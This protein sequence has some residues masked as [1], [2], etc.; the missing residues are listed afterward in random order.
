MWVKEILML[1]VPE[2]SSFLSRLR[3]L[4]LQEKQGQVIPSDVHPSVPPGCSE[5]TLSSSG[6]VRHP[7]HRPDKEEGTVR[8]RSG[9]EW[10][11]VRDSQKPR[12]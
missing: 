10:E 3:N 6:C 9:W 11:K 2:R 5:H 8:M 4:H 12:E 1:Q 7:P